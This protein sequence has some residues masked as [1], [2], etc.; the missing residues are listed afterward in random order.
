MDEYILQYSPYDGLASGIDM[1]DKN[2]DIHHI[3]SRVD[4][5]IYEGEERKEVN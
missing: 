2:G 1:I 4:G 5:D 3:R